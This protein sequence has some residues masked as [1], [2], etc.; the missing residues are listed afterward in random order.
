MDLL[1]SFAMLILLQ[2]YFLRVDFL[3]LRILLII[4]KASSICGKLFHLTLEFTRTLPHCRL[5]VTFWY[6]RQIDL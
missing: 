3:R 5:S 2:Q 4:L 1:D 6:L